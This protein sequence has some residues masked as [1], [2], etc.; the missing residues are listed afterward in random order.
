MHCWSYRPVQAVFY[1]KTLGVKTSDY[2][3][4]RLSMIPLRFPLFFPSFLLFFFS[5]RRR[6]HLQR[7]SLRY[8]YVFGGVSHVMLLDASHLHINWPCTNWPIRN[9]EYLTNQRQHDA[10]QQ[11]D[12]RLPSPRDFRWTAVSVYQVRALSY[13]LPGG[14]RRRQT[15]S[16][17][18]RKAKANTFCTCFGWQVLIVHRR[19]LHYTSLSGSI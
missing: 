3:E 15:D 7:W 10:C 16:R 1:W 12:V 2:D 11:L 9:A 17:F 5:F 4:W 6:K 13:L 8:L 18:A 14:N 19:I